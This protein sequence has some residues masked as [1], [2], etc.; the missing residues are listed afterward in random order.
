MWKP[1]HI[2][3][4]VTVERG[5]M[6]IDLSGCEQERQRGLNSRT[7]AGARVSRRKALTQP[8]APVNEGSF[9]ALDIVLPEGS[10]MMARYPA[11][12]TGWSRILPTVV[13]VIVR[14]LAPAMPDRTPAA[15]HGTMGGGSIIFSGIDPKTNRRFVTQSI[16]GAGWGGRPTEDGENGSVSIWEAMCATARSEAMELKV[17]ISRR[18]FA[19]SA[20]IAAGPASPAAGS[21]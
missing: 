19:A 13:D 3:A 6:I 12:M 17:P 7:L 20:R 10:I 5:S 21:A 11:P 1:I 15:H 9:R 2:H 18:E 8:L 4:K 14:S 16:E